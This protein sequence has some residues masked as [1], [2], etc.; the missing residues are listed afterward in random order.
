MNIIV[1]K[2]GGSLLKTPY[3]IQQVAKRLQIDSAEAKVVAVVSARNGST[4]ALLNEALLVAPHL[5]QKELAAYLSM[6]EQASALLLF[7]AMQE[8]GV[9]CCVFNAYQ[10]GIVTAGPHCDAEIE[11]VHPDNLYA[12]FRQHQV[13]VV[14]G[15][16]G[17]NALGELTTL[18]RG[19]SDL[20]AIALAGALQA[21]RCE[22][23]KDVGA[24]FTADPKLDPTAQH[25]AQ[26]SHDDMCSLAAHAR[27]IQLKAALYARDHAIPY[28]VLPFSTITTGTFVGSEGLQAALSV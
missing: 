18:G 17:L 20:T 5:S 15:F 19:G 11:S 1:Q 4:N 26:L 9:P 22:I 3:D 12:A 6:G 24:V 10:L 8:R 13:I 23:F 7:F 25:I 16:Q 27:V 2:Y 21:D 28:Q 14:M